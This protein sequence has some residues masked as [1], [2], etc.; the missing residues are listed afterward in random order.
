[1]PHVTGHSPSF[2]GKKKFKSKTTKPGTSGGYQHSKP[3]PKPKPQGSSYGGGLGSKSKKGK[4]PSRD[5]QRLKGGGSSTGLGSSSSSGS[6]GIGSS[7]QQSGSGSAGI[8]SSKSDKEKFLD[9]MKSDKL[10]LTKAA[11]NEKYAE[12]L[13][14]P[15]SAGNLYDTNLN[16]IPFNLEYDMSLSGDTNGLMKTNYVSSPVEEETSIVNNFSNKFLN[17]LA[18]SGN[19]ISYDD[20]RDAL[21]E[22]TKEVGTE[23]AGQYIPSGDSLLNEFPALDLMSKS[24]ATVYKLHEGDLKYKKQLTDSISVNIGI[25]DW[26]NYALS[27]AIGENN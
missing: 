18:E 3:K 6:A 15:I 19:G 7:G 5:R 23:G 12:H 16:E 21:I 27:I 14:R 1:M 11:F 4:G 20:V 24:I 26:E 10:V 25:D 13:D 22:T 17:K 9:Q 8:G 2:G